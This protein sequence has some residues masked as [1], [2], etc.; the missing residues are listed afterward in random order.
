MKIEQFC[1]L[2]KDELKEEGQIF[3]D[4]Q[5]K[6]LENYGSLSAVMILQM[7]ENEF[8]V[9]LNPRDFRKVNTVNDLVE[10]I[11]IDKFN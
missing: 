2:L 10:A 3:P 5:F 1:E 8:D 4:T 9:K 11:G 7:V 6:E